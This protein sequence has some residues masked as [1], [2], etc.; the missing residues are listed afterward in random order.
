MIGGPPPLALPRTSAH[1]RGRV[2]GPEHTSGEPRA[3]GPPAGVPPHRRAHTSARDLERYG[4]LFAGRTRVMRSSA[5]RDLMAITA[6]PEVISLAGGLPDTASFPPET[7]AAQM[8]RIAQESSAEALQ[9]GPT[10]GFERT[11]ECIGEVMGAEGMHPDVDDIIV[12]TG[13][14]QAIDLVTKTLVDPGDPVICEAPTY[15]GAVPVF[16]SYEADTHQV[17][18]DEDGMRVDELEALLDRLARDGRHPKFIYSVPSFQNPAGVTL[19]E[20][21]RHRLV[22]LARE[23]EVLVVED[24]PY[25]LLRYEGDPLPPLYQ[26]DGGD[27]VIYLGTFSKILSP[28]IRLGWCVAPPPVMEK[29]VLG[30]QATDLCTS[31]LTQYFVSEY[32]AEGRW[33]DYVDSLTTVYRERRDAM[34]DALDRYFPPQA[35]WSRPDGGLFLW[36]TL[37]PYIDTGDLLAKALR[38]DVAFVPGAAAYI[39]ARESSSMRLNF[40]ASPPDVI[41][42][43]IRRIGRVV[44][45][46]VALYETITGEHPV[47]P[48]TEAET[49]EMDAAG[50]EVLP[51]RRREGSGGEAGR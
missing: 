45:E 37:P 36:A 48:P 25:G 24:N 16:C 17:A 22:E 18:M 27:Y 21:R 3:D 44:W 30:K 4:A 6:R 32:F 12:T 42:E 7:F 49:S 2:T 38:D 47:A 15:P 31:T 40:S 43:G 28:G 46:Q 29:I 34:L 39:D 9:Y 23:R 10:E 26:L 19:S 5:M 41:R 14:Q 8:T 11:K 1:F 50:G 51:L 35:E 13:G 20:E 33:R